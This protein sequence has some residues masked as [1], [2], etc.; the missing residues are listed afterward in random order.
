MKGAVRAPY[1]VKG[2]T[3]VSQWLTTIRWVGESSLLVRARAVCCGAV[4]PYCGRAR[5]AC[6]YGSML[7]AVELMATHIFWLLQWL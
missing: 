5:A 3:N 6:S 4:A 1:F 7:S 2:Q